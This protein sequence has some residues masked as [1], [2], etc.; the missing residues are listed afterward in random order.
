M[1]L[2][3]LVRQAVEVELSKDQSKLYEAM[4]KD[5]V[6]YVN[7]KA[8]VAQLAITKALRLQ[9]IVSGFVTLE[10]EDGGERTNVAIK[11]NPR[12]LAL[13]DL[14]EQITVSHKC[15]VWAVFR[16]NYR[17]VRAVCEELGVK[18]VEVHGGVSGPARQEAVD[19]F[20]TDP[21]IKVFLGHPGSAGIGINLVAAPYSIFY[22][23]TFSLEQDLQAE[24]R[25]YRGG[26]EIHEKVTRYDL[27]AKGTIDELI[28][29][30][31]ADKI[32]I[33]DRVLKGIAGAL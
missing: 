3:P 20:N 15:L 25:N 21:T 18:F 17:A 14:L 24:A 26:S 7:D 19:A 2:P 23:R 13:K 16:E 12:A 1:D 33:S 29:K 27:V 6:A 28:T 10:G 8:C 32:D 22:S 5:F 11:D 31:L 30:K 4:K 9:Q